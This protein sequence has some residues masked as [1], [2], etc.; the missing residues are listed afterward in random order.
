MSEIT[1]LAAD[2]LAAWKGLALMNLQLSATLGRALAADGLSYPDYLVLTTLSD[3]EDGRCRVVELSDELGWEKSRASHHVARMRQ[4]GL[5]E[6]QRCP[7]DQRGAYV[8]LTDA[9]RLALDAAAPGHVATVRQNFVDLLT[10]EQLNAVA[11][12]SSVVLAHLA[13]DRD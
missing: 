1:W 3:H 12:I 4:R 9:G 10:S 5:V 7:T 13:N 6:K 8:V 2:E 11:T